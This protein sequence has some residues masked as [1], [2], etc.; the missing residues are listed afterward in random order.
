MRER[1]SKKGLKAFEIQFR[2]T[3]KLRRETYSREE[4]DE[5]QGWWFHKVSWIITGEQKASFDYKTNPETRD[6]PHKYFVVKEIIF[7]FPFSLSLS[8]K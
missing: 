3:Q 6:A 7:S 2:F 8:T 1:A 4:E 5:T